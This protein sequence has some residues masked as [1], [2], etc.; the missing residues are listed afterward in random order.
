[1][2]KEKCE[3][4]LTCETCDQTS[5]CSLQAKEVHAQER[6]ESKLSHIEHWLGSCT[7]PEWIQRWA[8]GC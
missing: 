2:A 4:D 6:L 3:K 8:L 5:S 1:V 7:I